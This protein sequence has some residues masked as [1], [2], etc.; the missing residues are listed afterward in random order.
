MRNVCAQKDTASESTPNWY[1][2]F[3][4]AQEKIR[5]QHEEIR[6]KDKRIAYLE[7]KV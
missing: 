3:S 6:K 4:Q 5:R 7:K 1:L 2:N